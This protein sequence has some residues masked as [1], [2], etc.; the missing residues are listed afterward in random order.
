ED[1]LRRSWLD[2]GLVFCNWPYED[3]LPWA[4]K[5]VRSASFGAEIVGLGPARTDTEWFQDYICKAQALCFWRGRLKFGIGVPDFLQT[6]LFASNDVAPLVESENA[7]PF[8]SVLPYFGPRA[9]EFRDI[10]ADCG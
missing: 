2:H 8:P 6:H 5:I 10:F 7:A 3:G 4:E 1:G 9:R